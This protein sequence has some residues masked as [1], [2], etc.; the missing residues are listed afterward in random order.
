MTR[1]ASELNGCPRSPLSFPSSRV[2]LA[3]SIHHTFIIA[4]RE[5]TSSLEA[6]LSNEGL[7]W[8]VLRQEP[9]P[10]QEGMSSSI[11]CLLNHHRAWEQIAQSN[12][13]ALVVEAD[14]VPVKGFSALP[15]PGDRH[16]PNLGILWLYTCASQLYSVNRLGYAEG[17]ST[18][19]VAYVLTPD[20]ARSLLNLTQRVLSSDGFRYST[21]DSEVDQFLRQQGFKNYIPFRNYGEHGGQPNPEH[22]H[23][24][25]SPT[26]RADVLYGP[27]A[28]SPGYACSLG[29]G[30]TVR[31]RS[32][33]KGMGR[34]L[35]GK[36]L[37][38][39]ILRQS[40]TPYRMVW[41][42]IARHLTLY[43]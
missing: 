30:M 8:T 7:G 1:D 16:Q 41:F 22:R 23:H 20:S 34:L 31:L 13:L 42:A 14:F 37:R 21:W 19:M 15:L 10:E 3:D 38:P 11:R 12:H 33:I 25:L 17:F 9:H 5:D 39:K 43:P 4:Y 36:F 24:G 29:R 35:V 2:A 26:H 28:F 27:L 6:A 40:S 18:S 32:R